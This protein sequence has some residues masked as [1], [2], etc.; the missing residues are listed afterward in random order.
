MNQDHS[1]W[2]EAWY[3]AELKRL[4]SI[5]E[6]PTGKTWAHPTDVLLAVAAVVVIALLCLGV[7]K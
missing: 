4:Q 6:H 7:F 2:R 3:E 1:A 5:E